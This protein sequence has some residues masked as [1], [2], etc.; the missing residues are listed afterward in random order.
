MENKYA[1]TG[2]TCNGCRTRIE[3]T[4]KELDANAQVSLENAEAIV[5]DSVSKE[6]VIKAVESLGY[7]AQ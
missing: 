6:D 1:I 3:N 5:S 4:L 7:S 2:M